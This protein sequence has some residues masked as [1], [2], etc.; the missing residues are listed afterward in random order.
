MNQ[1]QLQRIRDDKGFIA[2]LD[3][4]G[5]STPKAL[6][7]YGVMEDAYKNEE[8]M[9]DCIHKMRTRIIKSPSFTKENIIGAIL[10][11][12][13]MNSK[14]DGKYTGDFLWE[15]K[16]IV[17]FLKVDEGLAE[18]KDGVQLMKP[19]K[20]LDERLASAK[21]HHIFGTKMR[22]VIKE[23]D[24]KGI[25]EIVQQQYEY[26]NRIFEAGFVPIIEP[27]V[28]IHAEEKEK[29]EGYLKKALVRELEASDKDK[30]YMFKLTLPEEKDLYLELYDYPQTLKVV[31]LSGGYTR[32]EANRRLQENKKIV[33]SFSRGLTESLMVNQSEEE[34]DK[35]LKDSI[36]SIAKAGNDE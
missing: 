12:K 15:D 34:F 27:E 1:E 7:R 3:Q 8:E 35:V 20:G 2:A 31:A 26:A 28:D 24:E 23:Y 22:S 33:A 16:G 6:E 14:I 5:G 30:V 21:E 10:F 19:I 4:S 25:D 29:I 13:T 32:E 9:F 36:E 18:L 11:E 17:P